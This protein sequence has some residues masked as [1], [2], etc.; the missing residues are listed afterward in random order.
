VTVTLQSLNHTWGNDI[1]VLLVGPAGQKLILMSDAGTGSTANNANLTFSDGAAGML[2]QTGSLVSG[3]Y[4]PTDY[5]PATTF[6]SPA[7]AGPYATT[8]SVFNGQSA[9]GTWSLYVFDDGAGDQGSF[10]G[11]WSIAITA[12]N[13]AERLVVPSSPL[14]ITSLGL[15]TG[16]IVRVTVKGEVG[17]NCALEASSDLVNWTKVSEQLN[18]TGSMVFSEPPTANAIRFYRAVSMPQ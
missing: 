15:D 1:D 12:A 8:L 9:N 3:T 14:E 10:A 5:S 2:P 16:G 17:V 18:E 11:G 7:P 4:K 13:G 6:P